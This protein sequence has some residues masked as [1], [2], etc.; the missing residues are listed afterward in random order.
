MENEPYHGDVGPSL[1]GVADR[2]SEAELRAIVVNAKAVL[3]EDTIMPAFY[4]VI[5]GKRVRKKF[6]GKTILTAEQVEGIVTYLMSL[7]E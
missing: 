6:K 3:G 7:K 2:Y 5:E 1:D 4:T